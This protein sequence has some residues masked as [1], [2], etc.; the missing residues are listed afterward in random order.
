MSE[1][2]ANNI[3]N[4]NDLMRNYKQGAYEAAS[5]AATT[6]LEQYQTK[7]A[8]IRDH[9]KTLATE[10]GGEIG[11][12]YAVHHLIKRVKAYREGKSKN[13][14][15]ANNTKEEEARDDDDEGKDE[16][17]LDDAGTK[18]SVEPKFGEST[19]G[20][21]TA[22]ED[23]VFNLIKSDPARFGVADDTPVETSAQRVARRLKELDEPTIKATGQEGNEDAPTDV[24]TQGGGGGGAAR[25]GRGV[26]SDA[27]D[28]GAVGDASDASAF[29]ASS[30]SD[31]LSGANTISQKVVTDFRSAGG[32]SSTTTSSPDLDI[33]SGSGAGGSTGAGAEAPIA[34]GAP[35]TPKVVPK[36]TPA[37]LEQTKI[38]D[39][40]QGTDAEDMGSGLLDT[41]GE[42]AGEAAGAIGS[43][44][45]EGAAIIQGLVGIGEGIYHL[46]KGDSDKPPKP[47]PIVIGRTPAEVSSKFSAALPSADGSVED[48]AGQSGSF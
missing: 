22:P 32:G 33:N 14:K 8:E 26:A 15:E 7:A 20:E 6:H 44:V 24:G 13:T 40:I 41:A 19:I 21:G 30:A 3:D 42:G 17:N 12:V 5:E 11:G 43:V 47:P 48:M 46:L 1:T 16:E 45:A 9:Y 34:S 38:Q 27:T 39:K 35:P 31:G 23:S 25:A 28:L 10:G 29:S 37:E 18:P 4:A 36:Q 2:Y